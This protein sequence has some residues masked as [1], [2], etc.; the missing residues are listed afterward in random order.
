M[1]SL[2]RPCR[3]T[4]P[5]SIDSCYTSQVGAGQRL[6]MGAVEGERDQLEREILNEQFFTTRLSIEPHRLSGISHYYSIIG[7]LFRLFFISLAVN[8]WTDG[9]EHDEGG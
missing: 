5:K 6:V 2:K 1:Q 8:L 3:W 7:L 4:T 9:R